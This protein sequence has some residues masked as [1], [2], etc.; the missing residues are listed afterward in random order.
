[1]DRA[2]LLA[3]HAL[4]GRLGD[5]QRH[6]QQHQLVTVAYD[7]AGA[8]VLDGPDAPAQVTVDAEAHG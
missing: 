2:P 5:D 7:E 1:M 4:A 3:D 8:R 6:V